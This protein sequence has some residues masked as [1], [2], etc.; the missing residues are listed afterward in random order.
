MFLDLVPV[1]GVEYFPQKIHMIFVFM[2][3]EFVPVDTPSAHA[4]S[5]MLRV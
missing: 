2:F 5:M 1:I 3:Q 4:E